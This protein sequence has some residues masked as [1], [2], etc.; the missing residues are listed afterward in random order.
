MLNSYITS[1]IRTYVPLGVGVLVSWLASI[2][3][4][5]DS[6]ATA[7][8]VAGLGAVAA[9]AW[10]ALARLLERRWPKLG[11][12]LGV[13][14]APAYRLLTKKVTPGKADASRPAG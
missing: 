9:G 13:P 12:L 7:A 6:T 14:A 8:L 4:S 1:L 10:Y 11:V 3:I 2:G 5:V